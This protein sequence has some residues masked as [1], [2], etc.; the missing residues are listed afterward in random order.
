LG[1]VHFLHRQAAVCTSHVSSAYL[2]QV[3]CSSSANTQISSEGASQVS[4][5]YSGQEDTVSSV[6]T[7]ISSF[8]WSHVSRTYL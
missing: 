2:A 4:S 1:R 5:S 8:G 3:D 6:N 7:Q